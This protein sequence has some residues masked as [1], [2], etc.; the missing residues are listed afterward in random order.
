MKAVLL[1]GGEESLQNPL[2][3]FS[4]K[5][6]L[7][8]GN[9]PV[10]WYLLHLL[11]KNKI[12]DILISAGPS[13]RLIEEEF[14]DGGD[15]GVNLRFLE[16]DFPRGP[17]G[18]LVPHR[19]F[20]KDSS[21]VVLSPVYPG[22]MDLANLLRRHKESGNMAT[23][24]VSRLKEGARGCFETDSSMRI[25]GY[26]DSPSA[27]EQKSLFQPLGMYVFEPAVLDFIS[28]ESYMDIKEQLIP[29]LI[30]ENQTVRA[31]LVAEDVNRLENV[32]EYF[33]ANQALFKGQDG[34]SPHGVE[35]SPGVF[36][37]GR[38]TIAPGA[39]LKGPL[40]IGGGTI[41]E[42]GSKLEGPAVIGDNCLIAKGSRIKE[43]ILWSGT[44]LGAGA[45]MEHSI[46]CRNTKIRP[47]A[48]IR[49]TLVNGKKLHFGELALA[50]SYF[51]PLKLES[52]DN[53]RG[54]VYGFLNGF[55]K[56]GMDLTIAAVGLIVCAVPLLLIALAIKLDS[57]GPILYSQT[58][59]TKGGRKFSM[60]KFRSM[61]IDADKMLD[62]MQDINQSDGP[63]F[64][65]K[66]DPRLTPVG[67][68]L[69]QTSLDELP[70]L[71]NVLK[72]DMSLVGPRPLAM[73]EMKWSPRWRD[74][75]LQVKPGITGIW[76][77]KGR[78]NSQF[79]DW[80]ESDIDYVKNQSIG[81][82][83]KIMIKTVISVCKGT[84]AY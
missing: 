47:G 65:I 84:G 71:F 51:A 50:G 37:H 26:V 76:Q 1:A 79:H 64:K 23:V 33:A 77:I 41:I 75:R 21:F 18:C 53:G 24:A 69:R 67:K 70:Q 32:S 74:I 66:K 58:R 5:A 62:E 3:K 56:R 39:N 72:G 6:L 59:R 28:E 31:C 49:Y 27:K 22:N 40:L 81:L 15:L 68:F 11:Q 83:I 17:A 25:V 35:L 55:F 80:I 61:V 63:M 43:S 36:V 30:E 19:E 44:N 52:H 78:S 82:D 9:R 13:A 46:S 54:R 10:L 42:E 73:N 20:L 14:G 2:S 45:E 4:V 8:V 29:T 16:D 34:M 7:P 38:T 48:S 57:P 60:L 12:S